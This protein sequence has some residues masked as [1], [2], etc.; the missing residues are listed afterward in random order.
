M[1]K[2]K[3]QLIFLLWG[4]F[5]LSTDSRGQNGG[6]VIDADIRVFSVLAALHV[7]GP[8]DDP[9]RLNSVR[10][11]ISK[12]FRNLPAPLR[13]RLQKFHR[14]HSEGKKT[15]EQI[16]QYIS[17]AL[18]S[19]GPPDF[20][21]SLPLTSLPPDAQSVYEFLDVVKE[22]YATAQIEVIWSK[23]RH[24]YDEAIASYRPLIN[25]VILTSD[26][27][28]RIASGSFLDRRLFFIPEFLVP[29]N[30]FNART[31]RE[32]YYLVFGPSDKLKTDEIRHQYLHFLLDPFAMRFTLPRD[33]RI[34]LSKFVETA[35]NVENQYRTDLQFL[36]TES[37]IRA[38]ELRMNRV[39]EAKASAELDTYTRSGALLSRHFYETL[40]AFEASQ[41]GIRLY[42]PGLIK[43]IQMDKVE[44]S[45]NIAQKAPV[46]RPPELSE[47]EKLLQQA[48]SNLGSNNLEKAKDL[49]EFVLKNHDA[50]RGEALYG[51]GIIASIQNDRQ[52]AKEYFQ[53][54]LQSSSSDRS[55]KV[56]A[57]IYL[58]R[59]HDVEGNREDAI[60]E[61]QAALDV[62]DNT[63]NARE[64]AQQG[65][66]EPFSLRKRSTSP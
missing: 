27:Y 14:E 37:L 66:K 41:E 56:W 52:S 32:N 54:V 24:F 9:S 21:L 10:L 34:A 65:L 26:G 13:E 25:Q 51:L 50:T 16:S 40:P 17:L 12:E 42:Y 15:E 30:T 31:Y 35:P 60:L 3:T 55:V 48:N 62:G 49:F 53:R 11:S 61:Y 45:F 23:Y 57:H 36:V 19:E 8:D 5:S 38:I 47:V 46:Q 63:R 6:I 28:F 22:F 7:A 1:K 2:L 58:G 64:V 59:L 39:P 20:K 4:L 33:T 18:L 29:S 44:A 43:T